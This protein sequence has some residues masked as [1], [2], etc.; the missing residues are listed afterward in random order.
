MDEIH[1][2][3]AAAAAAE[4]RKK[5]FGSSMYAGLVSKVQEVK[6]KDTKT[7]APSF[8]NISG[9][10]RLVSKKLSNITQ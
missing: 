8:L 1:R 6:A 3:Q 10:K 7:L 2:E 4:K 5:K 9:K